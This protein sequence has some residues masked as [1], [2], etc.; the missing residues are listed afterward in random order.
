MSKTAMKMAIE[1]ENIS[2][3]LSEKVARRNRK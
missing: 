1:N 2:L 3:A